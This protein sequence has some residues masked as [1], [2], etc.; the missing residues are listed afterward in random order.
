MLVYYSVYSPRVI[1]PSSSTSARVVCVVYIESGAYE[2]HGSRRRSVHSFTARSAKTAPLRFPKTLCRPVTRALLLLLSNRAPSP[3]N[4][5]PVTCHVH[6]LRRAR[7]EAAPPRR[8]SSISI[9]F[10]SPSPSSSSSAR[11]FI[12]YPSSRR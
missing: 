9:R 7:A 4:Q 1:Y 3:S 8:T 11:A 12:S 5:S 10:S 2:L 6:S